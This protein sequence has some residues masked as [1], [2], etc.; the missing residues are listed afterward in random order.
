[1]LQAATVGSG[2]VRLVS[3]PHGSP[4]T[5]PN[6]VPG[7]R[8]CG[9][10]MQW[11]TSGGDMMCKRLRARRSCRHTK[12]SIVPPCGWPWWRRE[13]PSLRGATSSRLVPLVGPCHEVRQRC[14]TKVSRMARGRCPTYAQSQSLCVLGLACRLAISVL[15][16][17]L[18]RKRRARC[19]SRLLPPH[20]STVEP[21]FIFHNSMCYVSAS[22]LSQCLLTMGLLAPSA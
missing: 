18:Q 12:A 8:R 2:L 15:V 20:Q 19:A 6:Q 13:H 11:L 10:N 14:A 21:T 9:H 3:R 7:G 1:M 5:A 17:D 4:P 22:Y 16:V